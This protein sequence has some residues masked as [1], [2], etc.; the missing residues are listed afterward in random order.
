M[1]SSSAGIIFDQHRLFVSRIVAVTSSHHASHAHV[2]FCCD[3]L[4]CTSNLK[5]A[6]SRAVFLKVVFRIKK[7]RHGY[8]HAY[9][10]F[11]TLICF[12]VNLNATLSLTP[13]INHTCGLDLSTTFSWPGLQVQR[14]W[15]HLLIILITYTPPS[16]SLVHIHLVTYHSLMSWFQSRMAP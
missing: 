11:P 14:N 10:S 13:P 9:G 2:Q 3:L 15:K 16:S 6:H 5:C 12:L 8:G 7:S 4:C 1:L